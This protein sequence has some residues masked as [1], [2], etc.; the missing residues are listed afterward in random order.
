MSDG[1]GQSIFQGLKYGGITAQMGSDN[2][3]LGSDKLPTIQAS[4]VLFYSFDCKVH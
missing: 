1:L 2:L 4:K 3:K